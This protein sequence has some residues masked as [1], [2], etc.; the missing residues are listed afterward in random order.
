MLGENIKKIRINKKLGLNKTAE[1]AG[2]SGSYLSDI[3]N[4]KKENPSINTLTKIA[5]ALEVPLDQLTRKSAK[6]IIEDKLEYSNM[7]LEELSS[8]T[9][10]PK[11][12]F[13]KLDNIIPDEGDYER[14]QL[15]AKTL[16]IEPSKL[17]SALSRQEPQI[18]SEQLENWDKTL[19]NLKEEYDFFKN[20]EFKT[21][22][23]AMQF[24]LKQPSIMGYGGFDVNKMS[25]EDIIEF[26]NELLNQLKLL[27]YKYNR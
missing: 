1:K 6:T 17:M 23:A 22:E 19:P 9:N 27:S 8:K 24:I 26:A 7:T 13:D 2:I 16:N 21:P 5:D 3:E 25:N 4:G 11:I 10:I 15:I 14:I 18:T 20:G 12:F